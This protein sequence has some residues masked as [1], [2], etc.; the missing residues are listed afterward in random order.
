[1]KEIGFEIRLYSK[2]E[3]NYIK[4]INNKM[5]GFYSRK[6]NRT[7]LLD[8][9]DNGYYY[10]TICTYDRKELFGKIEGEKMILN[11]YGNYAGTRHALSSNK[12]IKN[13]NL[14]TI[15]GTFKSTASRYIHKSD[16]N[17]FRWQRSFY[18]HLIRTE[19]SLKNIREYIINNP[20]N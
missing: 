4:V 10:V 11:L 16:R 8:Y 2:R 17:R 18:D 19:R 9:A 5:N 12:N 13:N 15:I 6:P 3:K 14:S 7:H 20:A 1:M